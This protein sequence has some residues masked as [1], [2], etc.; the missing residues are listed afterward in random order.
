MKLIL[1]FCDECHRP[2]KCVFVIADDEK[3][4]I[5]EMPVHCPI[6][7]EKCVWRFGGIIDDSKL[8]SF[9]MH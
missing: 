4:T 5:P 1:Y 8:R 6:T 2:A 7:S 3:Y 9:L